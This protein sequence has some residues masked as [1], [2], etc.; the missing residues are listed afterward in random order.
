MTV[1]PILKYPSPILQQKGAPITTFDSDLQ[2]FVAD[3]IDTMYACPGAVGLA[4]QQVGRALQLFV[5]DMNAKTTKDALLVFINPTIVQ[6]SRNKI[7]REGCLS[8]PDYLA[9]VRRATKITVQAHN[10]YGEGFTHEAKQLEAVCIQHEMDH[11]DGVLMIDRIESLK[12]DWIRRQAS[13]SQ[14]NDDEE[15]SEADD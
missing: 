2:R 4:A 8:F 14:P 1:L 13:V 3:M 9:N 6:Q 10:Q 12:T 11:C 5:M 15:T 7:V